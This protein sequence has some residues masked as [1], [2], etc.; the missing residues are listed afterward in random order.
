MKVY[1]DPLRKAD[2]L[3]VDIADVNVVEV[4]GEIIAGNF[5]EPKVTAECQKTDIEMVTGDHV[6]NNEVVIE[7]QY[8]KKVQVACPKAKEDLIDFL[9]RC[10]ISNSATMLCPRCSAVFDKETA[11]NIEAFRPQ[12]KR[13]GKWVDNRPKFSFNQ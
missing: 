9:N 12:S 8:A 13:K 3:Y 6:C 11:K 4:S 10:K 2:S 1:V 7:D 5:V